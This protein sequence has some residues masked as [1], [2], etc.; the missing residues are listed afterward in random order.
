MYFAQWLMFGKL[1]YR[2]YVVIYFE[3]LNSSVRL[4]SNING[5]L[6]DDRELTPLVTQFVLCTICYIFLFWEVLLCTFCF[7]F[8]TR[9]LNVQINLFSAFKIG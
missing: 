3:Y 1:G 2:K 5:L 7:Q 9:Y 4:S 6:S 8:A